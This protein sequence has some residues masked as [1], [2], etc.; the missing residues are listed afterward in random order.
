MAGHKGQI[1]ITDGYKLKY[2]YEP[3]FYLWKEKGWKRGIPPR[4]KEKIKK[5][6]GKYKGI[7]FDSTWELAFILYHLDNNL[8]IKRCEQKRKYIFNGK[9]KTY[10]PDFE[11]DEGIIEIKGI[12]GPGWLAKQQYN[13]DIKVIYQDGIK[14]YLEYA[15]KKYVEN[16]YDNLF[17]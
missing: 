13:P 4:L 6:R 9:E 11:T 14:F 10:I 1:A 2:I 5:S 7:R 15:I 8:F 3:Q 12:Y 16:F 17:K